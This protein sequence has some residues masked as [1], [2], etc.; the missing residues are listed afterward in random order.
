VFYLS[1]YQRRD[2]MNSYYISI[3][4]RGKRYWKEHQGRKLKNKHGLDLFIEMRSRGYWVI[5]EG[6]TGLKI[7]EGNTRKATIEKLEE[8]VEHYG[9]EF[10]EKAIEK[11][12]KEF[13]LSPLYSKEV[14]YPILKKGG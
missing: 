4:D 6:K 14:L 2:K 3:S 7:C 12:I 11:A 8:L 1:L 10:F 9:I 5:T 13:G